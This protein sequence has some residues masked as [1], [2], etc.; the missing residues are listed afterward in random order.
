M[1]SAITHRLRLSLVQVMK[2]VVYCA[3]ASACVAPMVQLWRIVVVDAGSLQGLVAVVLF[4]SVLVPLAWVALSLLLVR[5]GAWRDGLIC[6][7]LL[8]SVSV[9]LG[10]ASW[11]LFAYTIPAYGNPFE[12]VGLSALTLHV[13]VI[14]TLV[15]AILWLSFRLWRCLRAG[16]TSSGPRH[17]AHGDRRLSSR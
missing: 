5:R 15:A 9:A 6:T 1:E 17:S 3:V 10:I 11:S 4:E 16:G 13:M 8:C 2:L 12:R 14:L 7:L